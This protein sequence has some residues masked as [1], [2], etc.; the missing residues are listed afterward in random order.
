MTPVW[1]LPGK[2]TML[3]TPKKTQHWFALTISTWEVLTVWTNN[4]MP[5]MFWGNIKSGTK[6]LLF[7]CFLSAC[8]ML[9]NFFKRMLIQKQRFLATYTMWSFSLCRGSRVILMTVFEWMIQFQDCQV[10]ISHPWR[11]LNQDQRIKGQQKLA[12]F[13]LQRESA[14]TKES[15]WRKHMSV[16]IVLQS[17]DFTRINVLNCT[18]QCKTLAINIFCGLLFLK[19]YYFITFSCYW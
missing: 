15:M 16:R 18:T 17:Q 19:A 10:D 12:E 2:P 3:A 8:W 13:A 4:Y 7:A 5:F 1:S 6:S 14:Q 9:T 11:L